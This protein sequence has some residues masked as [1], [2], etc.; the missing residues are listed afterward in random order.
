MGITG[1]ANW[2]HRCER[3]LNNS[4]KPIESECDRTVESAHES[5]YDSG[6]VV[7]CQLRLALGTFFGKKGI[8]SEKLDSVQIVAWVVWNSWQPVRYRLCTARWR[9]WS[10]LTATP[11][12]SPVFC[13]RG[14]E[15]DPACVRLNS[16]HPHTCLQARHRHLCTSQTPSKKNCS[17]LSTIH[18]YQ[19]GFKHA[20]NHTTKNSTAHTV[21]QLFDR[22]YGLCLFEHFCMYHSTQQYID[23]VRHPDCDVRS[24][25]GWDRP[26]KG[27]GS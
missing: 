18:A 13:G 16:Q 12:K 6:C 7:V 27:G 5:F 11:A 2:E 1:R 22:C 20:L 8:L 24:S 23:R 4:W 17:G 15:G 3:I 9:N 26:M 25:I 19:Q 10:S 21:S 14:C